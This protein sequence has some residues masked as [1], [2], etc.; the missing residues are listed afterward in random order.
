[1]APHD[2]LAD[3]RWR[4]TAIA[5]LAVAILLFLI[6]GTF[7][8]GLLKTSLERDWSGQ[9]GRPVAIG[10]VRR[11]TVFSFTP[12]I[13][14]GDVRV[15]QPA[16]AGKGDLAT[17]DRSTFRFNVFQA[18]FGTF[19]PRT[20]VVTGLRIALIR[21][22]HGRENWRSGVG[23][24]GG[25][26]LALDRLELSDARI[27]YRDALQDRRADLTLAAD[28]QHGVTARGT[29]TIWGHPVTITAHGPAITDAGARW[30]FE[31]RIAGDAVGMTIKGT[32][33]HPLDAAHMTA[34]ITAHAGDLKLIDAI[35]EAG[36][37]GTQPVRLATHAVHDG[38]T[39]TL[40]DLHG[41]IGGSDLTG[42]ITARLVDGRTKLDGAV[43][44][45]RLDFDDL[46]SDAGL[47]KARALTAEVGRRLVPNTRINLAHT[48]P[49]DGLISVTAQRL[50]SKTPSSLTAMRGTLTLD[51]RRLTVDPFRVDLRRGHVSGRIVV[52]QRDN[53]PVPRVTLAL[54]LAGADLPTLIGG[55][56]TVTGSVRG[57]LRL[58]GRGSTF[59]EVV[60]NADGR[61]GLIARDGVLPAKL[62]S[63]LGFDVARTLTTGNDKEAGL[64]C[65]AIGLAMRRGVGTI[66]PLV[67]D[68][69][70]AQSRGVGAIRFP[71]ETMAIRLTG[72]PKAKSVLRLPAA[73]LVG[74][75]IKDPRVHL[76]RGAK[77]FGNV[78][79]A[80]GQSITGDQ[81]PRAAD[82][83]CD[84]LASQALGT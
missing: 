80:I 63:E 15:P 68:T 79:K 40:T 34:D 32:M 8:F 58:V 42:H 65:I 41:T 17:I 60:A 73:I 4:W 71:D 38:R 16:W 77:S 6:A 20:I 83:D 26:G 50:V 47:A 82:A 18:L 1:V 5:V 66:D 49:A 25:T 46:A 36:L 75:T 51:H 12:T 53:G 3:R 48:G 72:A 10:S 39:W 30:P 19:R 11:E 74:G 29:G 57:R 7:P 70:R 45:G 28:R 64:R 84:A 27:S 69:T 35:V 33:A 78:L 62:A 52:D 21:D 54:D 23:H 67:I 31:A 81:P 44:F 55:G 24:K 61:V 2:L 9:I 76:Q 59:R 56:G 43:T 37:F 13:I 14:V 22:A